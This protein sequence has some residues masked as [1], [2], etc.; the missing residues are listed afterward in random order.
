MIN[1]N[2]L[3]YLCN[4][5][6]ISYNL[7]ETTNTIIIDSILDKWIVKYHEDIQQELNKLLT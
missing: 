6:N 2:H 5:Y 1:K 7:F 3:E 4:K